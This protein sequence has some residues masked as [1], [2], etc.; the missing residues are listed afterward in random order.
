MYVCHICGKDNTMKDGGWLNK[1]DQG[2][3]VLKQKTKDNFDLKVNPNDVEASVGPG[4]VGDGYDTTGR[5]Y[6]PAWG[7]QFAMGGSMPGAVG[8]T[9]ARTAG[10]APANGKYTKKT[11]ASA[12]N[13]KKL[14]GATDE[15]EKSV[16]DFAKNYYASDRF[17][18]NLYDKGNFGI[19]DKS[20]QISK[21]AINKINNLSYTY[22]P[23]TSTGFDKGNIINMGNPNEYLNAPKDLA[24]AH[25]MFHPMEKEILSVQ[26][27]N[28]MIMLNHNA[29]KNRKG[30]ANALYQD[31]VSPIPTTADN[32]PIYSSVG[33]WRQSK[34]KDFADEEQQLSST[35]MH[36]DLI[37]EV[38]SDIMALRYLANKK[39]IWDVTKSG[40]KDMTP[41]MLNELYKSPELNKQ[42]YKSSSSGKTTYL[43]S[44]KA[45]EPGNLKGVEAPKNPGLMLDRLKQRYSDKDLLY[46]MN[47]LAYENNNQDQTIAQNGKEMAFYQNG[48]D[49]KPKSIS[50][51]GSVIKDDRGQWAHPGEITEIGSNNITM[52]GVDYP[53]LGISDTGDTQMMYPGEDYNFDGD[54]V[55]EFPMMKSGGWLD[56]FQKGGK[57]PKPTLTESDPSTENKPSTG[58]TTGVKSGTRNSTSKNF[59][60]KEVKQIEEAK[61][62]ENIGEIRAAEEPRSAL[63]K[64]WAIAS[65]PMTA[66]QYKIAG[67]G[68][69][70][71][72]DRGPLNSLEHATNII[73]PL[74]FINAVAD[75]P[76]AGYEFV[77]DPSLENVI[78]LGGDLLQAVP[79][80]RGVAGGARTLGKDLS[81]YVSKATKTY[82]ATSDIPSAY[83]RL[84]NAI[85]SGSTAHELPGDMMHHAYFRMTPEQVTAKIAAE[86]A[87]A[88][89]G[90]MLGDLNMSINSTP[91][92]FTNATREA[93]AFTPIRTGEMQLTNSYGWRGKRVE[94]AI[95]FEIKQKYSKELS[96][97][98]NTQ[99]DWENR[100]KNAA[101][102]DRTNLMLEKLAYEED[103][104][105]IKTMLDYARRE[106]P[107]S[108]RKFIQN[109]KP[110]MDRPIERLNNATGLNF[111][112]SKVTDDYFLPGFYE[113]PTAISIKDPAAR[114][115]SILQGAGKNALK[116]F[117]EDSGLE[118]LSKFKPGDIKAANKLKKERINDIEADYQSYLRGAEELSLT[119]EERVN[120]LNYFLQIRNNQLRELDRIGGKG[121]LERQRRINN[122]N[123]NTNGIELKNGGWLNKYK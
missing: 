79:F 4:Y 111:P 6:S 71:H 101:P 53:V 83:N 5:N 114:V 58:I 40:V 33:D 38:R 113:T 74:S 12:Q 85:Y 3:L 60:Q 68:I 93:K 66:L 36:D 15:E 103:N 7:G 8:F 17:K 26:P 56:K 28:V 63:S 44:K 61:R 121:L 123:S 47:N 70:E 96:E 16:I 62:L 95:P 18:K 77:K 122:R 27:R 64:A 97:F 31:M 99:L 59:S 81:P 10:S 54:K 1:F 102:E 84:R 86:K 55:T 22:K 21:D 112:M 94:D 117:N 19:K 104:N 119:D 72:F 9:Y 41:E 20:A 32:K 43:P 69:P 30:D 116:T 115:K 48:L 80:T 75:A 100:I 82:K 57:L 34:I 65:N 76:E 23:L 88:P 50:K 108:Y 13:G 67:R 49:F 98:K 35:S 29:L 110:E 120:Q 14:Y 37:G 118:A 45:K 87:G 46:L 91:L 25:E 89:A 52:Q 11:K 24:F 109:Y 107:D 78:R 42:M 105:P 2:G 92:Y 39:G 51:N 73:N 90:A 106:E